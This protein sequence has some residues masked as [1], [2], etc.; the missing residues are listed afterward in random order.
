MKKIFSILMIAFLSVAAF[1]TQASAQRNARL[2]KET[3]KALLDSL[4]PEQK[5]AFR[6]KMKNRYDSLSPDQKQKMKEQLKSKL[7]S[8]PPKERKQMRQE[9]LRNRRKAN[10]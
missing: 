3:R 8:L 5:K 7:D 6:D 1:S 2:S 10:G 4:S 9:L